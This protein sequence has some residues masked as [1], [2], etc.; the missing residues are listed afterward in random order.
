MTNDEFIPSEISNQ[1]SID[2]HHIYAKGMGG[3]KTFIHDGKTYDIDCIENLIAITRTE[4]E[5][6]HDPTN[7][8]HLTK[9][10]LWTI[11]QQKIKVHLGI[12]KSKMT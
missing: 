7:E 9:D 2:L 6:A 12:G 3:S 10:E 11:H 1:M 5:A 4:H 8:N